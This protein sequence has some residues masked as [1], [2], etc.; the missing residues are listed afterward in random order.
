VIHLD[1]PLSEQFL[2][3]AIGES[4]AQVPAHREDD[5]LGREPET[6]E[7]RIRECGHETATAR[8]HLTTLTAR[9]HP[10]P[11]QQ[12]PLE[13]ERTESLS[14]GSDDGLALRKPIWDP[15]PKLLSPPIHRL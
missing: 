14:I 2:E 6:L 10:P 8:A 5:D 11:T 7:R 9:H 15:P 12:T 4:I 3:I 13:S 1:A